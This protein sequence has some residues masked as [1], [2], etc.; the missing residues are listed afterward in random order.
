MYI[1]ICI[2]TYTSASRPPPTSAARRPRA[3]SGPGRAAV[4][5]DEIIWYKV[6]S[7]DLLNYSI[8]MTN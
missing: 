1:Y 2:Y 4:V 7:Y 6:L 5:Y 8:N 3:A